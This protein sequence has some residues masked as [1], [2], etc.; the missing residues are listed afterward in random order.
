MGRGNA[1]PGTALSSWDDM[2]TALIMLGLI[3]SGAFIGTAAGSVLTAPDLAIPIF[4]GAG[5]IAGAAAGLLVCF[6]R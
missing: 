6:T 3:G 2:R 1:E 4:A 5:A